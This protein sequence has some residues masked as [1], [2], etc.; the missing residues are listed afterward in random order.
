MEVITWVISVCYL[1]LLVTTL[2]IILTD[3]SNYNPSKAIAWL[4]LIMFLPVLGII[5]YFIFG[6]DRRRMGTSER[7]RERFYQEFIPKLPSEVK[8]YL[9]SSDCYFN[10]VNPSY[11]N[12]VRLLER[13]NYS[14]VL[15]GSEVEIITNGSQKL[16]MLI[17]DLKKARNHI[18]CEFFLFRRDKTSRR[19]RDILMRKAEEGVEVR[20]VYDNI[21]NINI[22][23]WY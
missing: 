8:S 17:E 15:Y 22:P 3:R 4:V 9:Q 13:N 6:F 18:H 14:R 19:I 21:A 1:L 7:D 20:F 23:F 10:K 2:I 11:Q 16:E 12:L 5:L